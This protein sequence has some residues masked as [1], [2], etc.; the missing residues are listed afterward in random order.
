MKRAWLCYSDDD[1]VVI[2]F[3]E[4]CRYKYGQIVEIVYMEIIG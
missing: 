3:E 2:H 1:D 4:P